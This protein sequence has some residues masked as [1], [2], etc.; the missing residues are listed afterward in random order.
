MGIHH[1]MV[2]G[3]L[4][5]TIQ[6]VVVHPLA[7]VMFA[8]RQDIA[9]ISALYRVV[10]ILVHKM[11]CRFEMTLIIAHRPGCLV[12]H[13]QSHTFGMGIIVECLDVKIRIGRLEVEYI[14][15]FMTKPI[16]PS[17]VPTLDKH[18]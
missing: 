15:L 17:N 8:T 16:F 7:V 4:G 18:L 13:H 6:I 3:G 14:V 2:L 10:S 11:I 9:H 12:M 5:H 1:D